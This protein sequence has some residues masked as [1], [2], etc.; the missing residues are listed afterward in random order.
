[1]LLL[2]IMWRASSVFASLSSLK[3]NNITVWRALLLR[4]TIAFSLPLNVQQTAT[5][6]RLA[7]SHTHTSIHAYT[8]QHACMHACLNAHQHKRSARLLGWPLRL[9]WAAFFLLLVRPILSYSLALLACGSQ[10]AAE[11][12]VAHSLVSLVRLCTTAPPAPNRSKFF[13]TAINK[14][15]MHKSKNNAHNKVIF[16]QK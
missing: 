14:C 7:V 13:R 5:T 15:P 6:S 16:A 11:I 4:Q 2:L 10:F 3:E 9:P 12:S 8:P 1:M